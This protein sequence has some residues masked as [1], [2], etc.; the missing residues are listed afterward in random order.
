MQGIGKVTVIDTDGNSHTLAVRQTDEGTFYT[1]ERYSQG[2][3]NTSQEFKTPEDAI[4]DFTASVINSNCMKSFEVEASEEIQ[5]HIMQF[6]TTHFKPGKRGNAKIYS[7][8][9]LK[10]VV[11]RG[12]KEYI[13][14]GWLKGAMQKTG[15]SIHKNC[16]SSDINYVYAL[17]KINEIEAG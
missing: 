5:S 17:E 4:K 16:I 10:H 7:S 8:Y 11:E 1:S 3:S 9:Y 12:I 14:N 2:S 6:I 13:S 15:F